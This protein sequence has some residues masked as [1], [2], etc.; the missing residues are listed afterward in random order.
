MMDCSMLWPVVC[1]LICTF[2]FASRI[3][4]RRKA[5]SICPQPQAQWKRSIAASPQMKYFEC[6]HP[7]LAISM[8]A[9]SSPRIQAQV[10]KTAILV[11]SRSSAAESITENVNVIAMPTFLL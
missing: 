1:T 2:V 10:V 3:Q 4:S 6:I 9:N 11:H 8:A 5:K 7:S